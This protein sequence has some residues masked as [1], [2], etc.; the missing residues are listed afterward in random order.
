[1]LKEGK[2]RF[3]YN[4]LQEQITHIAAP[5]VLDT[6]KHVIRL[7]F[8]YDGGGTG[9]GG[10]VV[11]SVDGKKVAEDRIEKTIPFRFSLDET[12]DVGEDTGTPLSGDYNVPFKFNGGIESVTVE[13]L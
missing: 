12:L 5:D 10:G 6:G 11:L 7:E 3:T 9:K 8:K 1:M 4:W 13:L 2:P